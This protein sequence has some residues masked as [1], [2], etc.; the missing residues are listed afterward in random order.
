MQKTIFQ[1]LILIESMVFMKI[2]VPW[3][4]DGAKMDFS[5]PNFNQNFKS[6]E[7][8]DKKWFFQN[9]FKKEIKLESILILSNLIFE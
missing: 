8:M 6:L 7:N 2:Y 5:T 4:G 1:N 9:Y 3:I